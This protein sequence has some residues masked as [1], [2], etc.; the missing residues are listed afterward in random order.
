MANSDWREVD[1]ST[2]P[3]DIEAAYREMKAVYRDYAQRKQAFEAL[4]QEH[5][6]NVL[7]SG[8]ELKFGYNFGKLSIAIGPA[9]ERKPK[10]EAKT[11]QSLSDWLQAQA[12]NGDRS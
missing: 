5:H 3:D 6:A 2:L 7:P 1:P 8:K 9:R 12:A 11:E 4:M 10:R